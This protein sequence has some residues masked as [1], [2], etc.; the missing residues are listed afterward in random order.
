MKK[1]SRKRASRVSPKAAKPL[2]RYQS[3]RNFDITPE[4]TGQAAARRSRQR[5]LS[6]VV[7]KHEASHL[8]Y[9]FRLEW[10]G[11][12]KSWAVAKGPS[13]DPGDRRLAVEV[14]DHPLAYGSFEGIIPQG[15][16]G[17]GTVMVW[18]RGTWEPSG[19]AARQLRDGNLKFELHGE[20]L[21]G[22]WALVRMKGK[23]SGRSK[24]SW[25]LIKERDGT[26][27]DA[28]APAIVDAAPL[29]V[30]TARD[31]QAIAEAKDAVWNA[32]SSTP[33]S[34]RRLQTLSVKPARFNAS[35][36]GISQDS[37]SGLPREP[38]PRFI[39]PQ[40]ASLAKVPVRGED[41]VYEIKLDGYR[42]QAR[43]DRNSKQPVQ[44]LTRTGLD[45]TDS[46]TSVA[47]ALGQ[48]SAETALLDGELVVL[49]QDGITSFAYL[50]AALKERARH[51]LTYFAFDLLHL[52][53]H[54]LRD[55]P[56]VVRKEILGDLLCSL[57]ASSHV[58]LSE[59][60]AGQGSEIFEKACELGAEGVISKLAEGTYRS[61]RSQDWWKLKCHL[62]QEFV[63]VGYTLPSNGIYGVGSLLLGYYEGGKLIYAGRTGTGFTR[64]THRQVRDQLEKISASTPPFMKAGKHIRR[65]VLW[66]RPELVAQ[67]SFASWTADGVVRQAA[68]K[69]LRE[70]K[71]AKSVQREREQ[72]KPSAAVRTKGGSRN[73]PALA[74]THVRLTH[75][76]KV[77]DR[78]S[79][80]TKKALA[81]Y[82]V[83]IA[84]Y[85][86]PYLEGRAV[87]IVRCPEGSD[88]SCFFQ[89][90]NNH[91]LPA[92]IQSIEIASRKTGKVEPFITVSGINDL[93]IFAQ[94][95]VL[96][97]HA[98]GS[99][100]EALEN[101]DRLTI[102]L[103]PDDEI[104]WK[105]LAKAAAE[106][107]K[108]LQRAGLRSFLK[109]TGGK[110]LHVVSPIEPEHEW[111]AIKHFTHQ[112]VLAM[113]Q[114]NPELYL[115]RMTKAARKGK[116][117]L[118]YLRN[119]RG[120]T[121]IAPYS[122][123]AR[124]GA[125][126]AL[127]LRWTELRLEDR[128]IFTVMEFPDWRKRLKAD[129]WRGLLHLRQHLR[130]KA[131]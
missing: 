31:M 131:E 4:P 62:E 120:A 77:L 90:H 95:N 123:R 23:F 109:S 68:F 30:L 84:P 72:M 7:Q 100:R 60:V 92:G 14:E 34:S 39:P 27:H 80:L 101:P 25:L 85:M 118:D 33:P 51:P 106:V 61:G 103:D 117:Y 69:G 64:T 93:L 114:E 2:A 26:E 17:G 29:S 74:A 1:E 105:T 63:I 38:L 52:D 124:S 15:Q 11:V 53:G 116:I 91:M 55:A 20:K 41:R 66:V 104:D 5:A 59:H 119:E 3:M 43:I 82:Y 97:I 37:L 36:E 46:M 19:D 71:P 42:I 126:V 50:Q 40:L 130:L 45:W 10:D 98:W 44:L 83:E 6:F 81:D 24:P 22:T 99:K 79:G 73:S 16:Y 108:R 21:R 86:V 58:R 8:H 112:L 65:G 18:D 127:P 102:D 94:S 28:N 54:S 107:R 78:D 47:D 88:L 121:A 9:D 70:D 111:A 13:Y 122:P 57:P 56:L 125:P 87:S 89:K 96:E 32:K 129:P 110:G 76:E 115:T 48:L 12:L 128:P 49:G 35:H 67:V 113:E 75:G